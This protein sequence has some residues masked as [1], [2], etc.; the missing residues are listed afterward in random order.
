MPT[1]PPEDLSERSFRFTCDV[2][3]YCDEL[4]R[5]RGLPCRLAYQL[6]DAA[7]SVG[8]NRSESKSAYSDKEFAAKN[9]IALK[10]C[11]EARFWL[12][13]AAAKLLGNPARRARLLR[14]SNEL[15]AIY[16]VTV[17][18]LKAKC[19]KAGA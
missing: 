14:E 3:D 5:L 15:V 18:K 12:R 9:A 4:V 17:R 8:A 13:V 10:E 6:F 16:V 2:Y 7:G 11:R 1:H 19:Q